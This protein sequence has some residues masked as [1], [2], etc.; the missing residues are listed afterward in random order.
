MVKVIAV[1]GEIKSK[2]DCAIDDCDPDFC[3]V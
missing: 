2:D 1:S 3:F